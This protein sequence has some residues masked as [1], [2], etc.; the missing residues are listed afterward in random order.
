ME[1]R[2]ADVLIY[3]PEISSRVSYIIDCIFSGAASLSNSQQQFIAYSGARINYSTERI[4]AGEVWIIPQGLLT[5]TAIHV[6][7][8]DCFEW[9]GSK[10]FFRTSGDIPFDVFSAAF[11]LLSRYEEYLPHEFDLYGRYAH[12]N[13]LAYREGF[14]QLPLVNIW[15]RHLQEFMQR[16]FS[17][18]AFRLQHSKFSF[19]PTYDIDNAYSYL[20]KPV[21]KN[22]LGFYRDLLQG[23][24][25]LVMERGNVYSGR[26]KDPFDT[27]GWIDGLHERYKLSPI[28]FFLT[29]IKR[30]KYDKNLL[31]GSKPLQ[32]L[33]QRLS[34]KYITGLHPSW[35]SGTDEWLLDKERTALQ[36]IIDKPIT[37]SRNHYLRFSVPHTYRQLIAA[38][39][40]KD[41]SMAYGTVNGFRA[42]YALPFRWYDLEKESVTDLELHPFCFMEAN[43]FFEQHYSAAQAGEEMQYFHDIVKSVNGEFITLFHNHF[44]TE[45]PEWIGWRSMYESFLQKNFG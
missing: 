36:S 11:Y 8:I 30:G 13:S 1:T 22:V 25:D 38:G 44:L 21:W 31:A 10:M 43:S 42:S 6:Q 20:H 33:Y 18:S 32:Q 14:L 28:Y 35:Q 37:I 4:S 34:R 5:Q 12:T 29:V 17:N 19:V 40:Q 27:Y 2:N 45:Q 39:I 23:K 41:Y 24:F 26:K 9:E 15:I 7:A 16:N 3:T